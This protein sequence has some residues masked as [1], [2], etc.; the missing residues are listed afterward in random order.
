MGAVVNL[1]IEP[2][3]CATLTQQVGESVDVALVVSAVRDEGVAG[4]GRDCR[5]IFSSGAVSKLRV[6]TVRN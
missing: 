2:N 6:K 1:M 3:V 5:A 4:H